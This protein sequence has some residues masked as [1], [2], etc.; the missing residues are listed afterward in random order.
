MFRNTPVSVRTINT[1]LE[2][3]EVYTE[4]VANDIAFNVLAIDEPNLFK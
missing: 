3:A 2:C 1:R 4:I